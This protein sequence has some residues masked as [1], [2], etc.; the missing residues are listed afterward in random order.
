MFEICLIFSGIALFL[1]GFLPLIDKNDNGEV[2]VMNVLSGII[3][4]LVSLYGIFV[5]IE[6]INYLKIMALMLLAFLHLYISATYIWDLQEE[7]LGWFSAV[8]ALIFIGLGVYFM[9]SGNMMFGAMLLI[10]SVLFIAYFISRGLNA[11]QTVSSWVI[12]LEGLLAF[13]LPGV[14]ILLNVLTL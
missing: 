4:A 9:L 1:N 6:P 7:S 10:W 12:M 3:I 5:V 8:I 2:V 13:L 11:L 14:L